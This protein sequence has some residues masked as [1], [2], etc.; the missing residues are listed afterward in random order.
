[1]LTF[2]CRALVSAFCG[3]DMYFVLLL[4]AITFCVVWHDALGLHQ[5]RRAAVI[6]GSDEVLGAVEFNP[7]FWRHRGQSDKMRASR[8]SA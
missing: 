5:A 3:M 6:I 1:M 8:A 4:R 7:P 2:S